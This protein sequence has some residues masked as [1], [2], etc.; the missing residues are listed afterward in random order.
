MKVRLTMKTERMKKPDFL[1]V[2]LEPDDIIVMFLSPLPKKFR[3][4]DWRLWITIV[5]KNSSEKELRK[6]TMRGVKAIS[7]KVY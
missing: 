7:K 4:S 5:P 3:P 6:I 2:K 1:N